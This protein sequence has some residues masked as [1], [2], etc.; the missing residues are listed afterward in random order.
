[1]Y[2]DGSILQVR[3]DGPEAHEACRD[4]DRSCSERL[5]FED[6]VAGEDLRAYVRERGGEGIELVLESE[7]DMTS[8]CYGVPVRTASLALDAADV[9]ALADRVGGGDADILVELFCTA[10]RGPDFLERV[11]SVLEL[12]GIEPETCAGRA[13]GRVDGSGVVDGP[14]PNTCDFLWE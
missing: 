6:V 8:L 3:G 7:G 10:F 11:G 13:P 9:R 5:L 2:D 14:H 1:M 4:H 12:L